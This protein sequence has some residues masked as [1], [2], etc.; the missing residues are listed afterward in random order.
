MNHN[1]LVVETVTK[2]LSITSVGSITISLG[3]CILLIEL[4]NKKWITIYPELT[5]LFVE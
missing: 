5:T 4:T 3:T 1:R 2:A